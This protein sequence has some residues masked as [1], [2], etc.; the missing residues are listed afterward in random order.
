MTDTIINSFDV[1]TDAQG[2]KSRIRVKSVENISLDGI[3]RLRGVILKLAVSGK[4]VRQD[5]KDEPADILLEKIAEE[6]KKLI[7]EGKIKRYKELPEIEIDVLPFDIPHNWAWVRFGELTIRIGSG[8]TPRGGKSAYIKSGTP[9]LRSQNILNDGLNLSDV[10]YISNETHEKMSNT[11]VYPK[12][13]LLNITGGSLGRCTIFPKDYKEANVSQ[14]V[15][16]IRLINEDFRFFI[17]LFLLSPHGQNLIWGRQVGANREG[18][19]K[20]VLELFEIP[21]PPLK[22]QNRIVAKVEELMTLCDK[23]EQ[24]KETNLKTHQI[25]VKTI[26]E[27]LTQAKDADELQTAWQRMS[28]HFDTLFCTEDSIE[29]LKQTILQLGVMGKL[30]KQDPDDESADD[31]FEKI[32]K[33]KE[34]LIEEG[35]IK[36]QKPLNELE[37]KFK[38]FE[39]PKSWK[40]IN[41]G[42]ISQFINGDR[43]KNYP[44]K[45]EYQ[46]N[47]IAWINT[48]HI[49][50]DGTLSTSSMNYISEEKFDSL[51]SGKIQ[52]GDLV[53]C[54]RGA[55]FG[56]TAFVEP[57]EEGAIASS[58]MIIRPLISELGKFIY[59]YLSS[60]M[61]KQQLFR[62][63]NGSAQPN[64]SANSVR[65]YAFPVAPLKEQKR[66]VIKIKELFSICDLLSER[67]NESQNLKNILSKVII[68][69]TIL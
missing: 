38:P 22:E 54:L 58:L 61:A 59:L 16:I 1:W 24:E 11:K 39:L 60:P 17:H 29:Q 68:E 19:S 18:L 12:D 53:Y 34:R 55:T 32:A 45:S 8:S 35:K 15:S 63:D 37:D 26:L 14:H 46:K 62:F 28:T 5:T 50:T 27:T 56:K 66:I 4:L 31:L 65:H 9:F 13:I 23:L 10:A 47:G 49:K 21:I 25:L 30:V 48:G 2:V 6:K 64:L 7:E 20:K 41:F 42:E 33:E 69:K 36:K 3:A 57:Y 44:N 43:S 67:I 51:R 40:W 52:K